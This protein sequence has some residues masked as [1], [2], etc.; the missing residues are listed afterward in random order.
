[1]NRD[2]GRYPL[3]MRSRVVSFV[4]LLSLFLS[5]IAS[6]QP[7]KAAVS[8]ELNVDKLRPGDTLVLAITLDIPEGLHA[9]SNTPLEE[10]LIATVAKISDGPVKLVSVRYPE[11]HVEDYPALG[12]VSVYTGKA[13]LLATL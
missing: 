1:M 13:I 2:G 5:A 4:V 11:A 3:S 10:S 9:Q 8:T 7:R 6:A 12:K